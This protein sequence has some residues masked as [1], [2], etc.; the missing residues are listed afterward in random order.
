MASVR[1]YTGV[2]KHAPKD[3]DPYEKGIR[4]S[5]RWGKFP[6]LLVV[7]GDHSNF[8][9]WARPVME[10]LLPMPSQAGVSFVRFF[11]F[12]RCSEKGQ[13]KKHACHGC[14]DDA[15]QPP[16]DLLQFCGEA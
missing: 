10:E 15:M 9:L 6:I 13:P 16:L 3:Y 2:S 1:G 11:R 4:V 8:T 7:P 14:R 12:F 5:A